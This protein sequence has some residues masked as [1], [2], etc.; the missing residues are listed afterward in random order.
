MKTYRGKYWA[1]LYIEVE[2]QATDDADADEIM[3]GFP[4]NKAEIQFKEINGVEE[5]SDYEVAEAEI[6]NADVRDLTITLGG[7]SATIAE[8]INVAAGLECDLAFGSEYLNR[9]PMDSIPQVNEFVD[10]LESTG[11]YADWFSP[12]NTKQLYS[13]LPRILNEIVIAKVKAKAESMGIAVTEIEVP[14]TPLPEPVAVPADDEGEEC[15]ICGEMTYN[16]GIHEH[17]CADCS[18]L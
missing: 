5:R 1:T 16:E 6:L 18:E 14:V 2:F 12:E 15:V 9:F 3:D 11:D 4:C 10:W 13:L 17:L 8:L 7:Q